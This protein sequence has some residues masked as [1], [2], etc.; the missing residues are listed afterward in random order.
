[1]L[2]DFPE[3]KRKLKL[4][5]NKALSNKVELD[6]LLSNIRKS[7]KHEGQSLTTKTFDGHFDKTSYKKIGSEFK[8]KIDDIIENGYN[9]YET[10]INEIADDIK[11]QESGIIY[12]KLNEVTS[13]AGNVVASNKPLS[14]EIIFQALKKMAIDFNDDGTPRNLTFVMHPDQWGKI[15]DLIPTWE[16]DP[17]Y[18]R[19]YNEILEIKRKEW[20]DRESNRKL[21]D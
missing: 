21:V 13:K 5:F 17:E 10:H 4:D 2:P 9:A 1:M 6:P 18:N 16:R 14:P 7:K 12:A 3:I 20:D 11:K 19:Q 15:K 8:I